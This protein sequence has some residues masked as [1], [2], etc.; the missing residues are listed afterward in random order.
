MNIELDK[1]YCGN[2]YELIKSVPDKSVD[3]IVTDP[4]YEFK[5]NGFITGF[6]IICIMSVYVIALALLSI[7]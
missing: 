7:L 5:G 6:T 1:I 4:P 3:L 2:S